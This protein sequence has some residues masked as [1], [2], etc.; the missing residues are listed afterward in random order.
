MHPRW[1]L[2]DPNNPVEREYKQH[3][4]EATD[5]W[6]QAFA[7]QAPTISRLFSRETEFDLVQFMQDTLQAIHPQIMWEF[8]PARNGQGHRLCM[9]PEG[10]HGLRPLVQHVLSRAP[11][12]SPWEFYGY[13]LPEPADQVIDTVDARVGINV[14]G[15]RVS[16]RAGRGRKVDLVFAMPPQQATEEQL[17]QG[18]FVASEALLG[19]ETLD[20]WIGGI[21]LAP[22]KTELKGF[23]P[24]ERAQETI[25]SVLRSFYEQLPQ[26]PA[27]ILNDLSQVHSYK[28]EPDEAEEYPGRTD[29]IVGSTCRMEVVE[30]GI[31]HRLFNSQ[32][33]TRHKERF[34]YIKID[35][36]DVPRENRVE[37]RGRLEDPLAEALT[38]ANVG[39][40]T[41]GGSGILYSYIDLALTNVMQALPIIRQVLAAQGAPL[42]TWLLFM[43]TDFEYEWMGVYPETPPPPVFEE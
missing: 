30:A 42:R 34:C 31:Y 20:A 40:Q 16:A 37:F 23:L 29:L 39:G 27:Y 7:R 32:C 22:P 11:Q 10:Q 2:A 17:H 12:L 9:T 3:A 13:R 4:L 28:L 24:L 1:I 38:R 5:R 21:E 15:A 33:H 19:E 8:G 6:W 25:S 41:G 43:D 18:A 35:V 26:Q 14:H 36:S